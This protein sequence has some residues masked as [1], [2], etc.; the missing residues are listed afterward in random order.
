MARLFDAFRLAGR[1][2]SAG[3][4]VETEL[5]FH[6][7]EMEDLLRAQG[8]SL[9]VARQEARRRLG[10]IERLRKELRT[11]AEDTRRH[12]RRTQWIEDLW[13]DLRFAARGLARAPG[14]TLVVVITLGLAI[15][16]NASM[17]GV[18]D[19][20]LLRPPA[21]IPLA[22]EIR[23]VTVARWIGDQLTDPWDAVSYPSFRALRDDARSF[24]AVAAVSHENM[25][26]GTGAEALP[27]RAVFATGQYFTMLGTRPALGRFFGEEDD[28]E[29]TGS[30]VVVVSHA[31]W[32][33]SMGARPDAPGQTLRLDG[34]PYEVIGVAP[35]GFTGTELTPVDV[36]LPFNAAGPFTYGTDGD[37]RVNQGWQFINIHVRL[38][39]GVNET[40]AATDAMRAYQ[41]IQDPARVYE[42]RAVPML[43]SLIA[44]RTPGA[45]EGS[46]ARVA[47]WLFGVAAIVLIIACANVANLVLARGVR[48]ESEMAVRLAIGGSRWRLMRMLLTESVLLAGLGAGGGLL[49]ARWGGDVMRGILLPGVAW[50]ASGGEGRV[51]A[52]TALATIFAAIVASLL[53]MTRAGRTTLVGALHGAS[54]RVGASSL[55]LRTGLLLV[56]TTLCTALLVGAGL[57]VRSLERVSNLDFGIATDR[58]LNIRV[59]LGAAGVPP[60]QQ[61]SFYHDAVQRLRVVPGVRAAGAMQGVPFGSNSA[62]GIKVPGIDSLRDDL[63]GGGPYFFRVTPGALEALGVRLLRGRLFTEADGPNGQPVAIISDL[64]A[65]HIWPGEDALGKCFMAGED[66]RCRE[67]VGIVADLHRQEIEEAPFMLYFTLVDQQR[68]VATPGHLLVATTGRP[69]LLVEPVRRELQALRG[70]LPYVSARPFEE[71]IAPQKRSWRLGATMFSVFAGLSLLIAAVGLYGVL[72]YLVSER[73]REL[74]LRAALGATPGTL[75]EMVVRSGLASALVGVL[76]GLGIVVVVAGKLGSLLYR[77]SPRDPAVLA[78]AGFV[79]VVVALAASIVP[80]LRATRVDPMQA[81]R[82]E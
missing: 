44:A 72:S 65:R 53:P 77:T 9:D 74:G 31:F 62:E 3:D 64:M 33:N 12:V 37:W 78:A 67:I 81:L 23:R 4:D 16:A 11:M 63:P 34:R 58:L 80:G 2:P 25:S 79:V 6:L 75:L 38:K 48:R 7:A 14:F 17:F 15:G 40:A 73:T 24:A 70:D 35:A 41:N 52:V 45:S 19:R 13:S 51:L 66:V 10:D 30:P 69:E 27:I 46:D 76:L 1:E 18:V 36:W 61:Q 21:Q 68:P 59:D 26:T 82:T 50:E 49:L 42:K 47:A 54:R 55:R 5:Q 28:R 56:Q 71:L 20:L 29:P 39:A 8:A 43:G 22:D 57:F 60:E 32:R